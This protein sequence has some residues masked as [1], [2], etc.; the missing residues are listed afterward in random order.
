VRLFYTLAYALGFRPWEAAARKGAD[1]GAALFDREEAERQRPYGKALDLGC[2]TGVHSVEL[3]RRGWDVTGVDFVSK[4]VREAE[5][6]ARN[7]GVHVR[8]I[9]ADVTDLRRAGVGTGYSFALDFGLFHG[10]GSAERVAM[11]R[12][13]TAVTVPG[14]TLLMLAFAPGRRGPLPAGA[15]RSDI[16]GAF[17]EWSLVAEEPAPVT[18]LPRPLRSAQP[19]FYRL[20]RK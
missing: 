2:G 14:A 20:R 1:T 4:A 8:F 16:Q 17:P 12:E 3:A 13:V 11:G 5:A 7:A 15:S 6:R 19:T 18:G 9:K 10:L